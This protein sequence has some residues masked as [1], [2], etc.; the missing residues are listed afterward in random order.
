MGS[1][2]SSDFFIGNRQRL[3]QLFTGKAPIVISAN[4]LMQRSGDTAFPFRQDSNFWY[5]TGINDPDVL[6]VMDKDKEYLIVPERE[7]IREVFDGAIDG[8]H[9]TEISGIQT[10]LEHAEGW[11]QL[12]SRI[13]KVKHV[14][15]LAAQPHYAEHYGF[16]TNPARAH[17]MEWIQEY[18]VN[19]EPLDLREHLT[20]MRMV[21][22]EPELAAIQ[23]AIDITEATIKPLSKKLE[24]FEYEYEIEA[25]LTAGFRKRGASG[26]A[27]TPIVAAGDRAC[28]IHSVDNNG[29]MKGANG[30]LFD[31]GAEVENYS[32]D[33][34][35]TFPLAGANKRYNQVY[36]AVLDAHEYAMGLLKPGVLIKEYE[37]LV[38][39]YMG[40]KLRELR[41]IK[42]IDR[43]SV[44][45]YYPHATS[46]SL[47]LDTHDTFLYDTPLVP[48][49]VLTVE[50]GI[51]IPEEG[52]GVRIE[53]DVLIT[54]DGIKVL[55]D[56][57]PR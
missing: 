24:K 40:E 57:L 38:E 4:G 27:F 23:Q 6:L 36:Q 39:H 1:N 45:S 33:I 52:I 47:G 16:Y 20:R 34:S 8:K 49:M 37:Q 56:G 55:S 43:E 19:I 25:A 54:D 7:H 26:H 29:A 41:L 48:N 5:L 28:I 32:A 21:K 10:V 51:Y 15:T 13:K 42:T 53:D 17:L 14:A 31:V 50:P 46:H 22:Q 2:F 44:R 12:G 11:K 35:R 18:N 9:L 3:R 30:V